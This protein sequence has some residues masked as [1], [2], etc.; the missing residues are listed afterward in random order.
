MPTCRSHLVGA[1]VLTV[2][3]CP[4]DRSSRDGVVRKHL[5]WRPSPRKAQQPLRTS[6]STRPLRVPTSSTRPG[7][8][9]LTR[10]SPVPTRLQDA[11]LDKAIKLN[12]K[13]AARKA[14]PL[15]TWQ[16]ETKALKQEVIDTISAAKQDAHDKKVRV[17]YSL[18]FATNGPSFSGKWVSIMEFGVWESG[19]LGISEFGFRLLSSDCR[20]RSPGTLDTGFSGV[21]GDRPQQPELSHRRPQQPE[22]KP[23]DSWNPNPMPIGGKLPD[24]FPL[25]LELCPGLPTFKCFVPLCTVSAAL[26]LPPQLTSP[27]HCCRLVVGVVHVLTD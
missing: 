13:E 3:T 19:G 22:P 18:S 6:K 9:F 27:L 26:S 17:V 1:S 14:T 5:P 25:L 12:A 24:G 10:S 11:C 15:N 4:R 23:H 16:K 7:R 20:G 21:P 8:T 2:L